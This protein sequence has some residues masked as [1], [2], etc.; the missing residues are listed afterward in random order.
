MNP[1]M[2]TRV[3]DSMWLHG[4]LQPVVAR[5][6]EGRYQVIDGLKRVYSAMD[7]MIKTLHCQ[8]LDIDLQQAKLLILSYKSRSGDG[9]LRRGDGIKRSIGE[10]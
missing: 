8:V 7:L 6:Y 1:E 2:V 3:H 10:P 9:S 5:E 4:Q